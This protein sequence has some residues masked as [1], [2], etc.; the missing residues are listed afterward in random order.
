[1]TPVG[2]ALPLT[3]FAA[4]RA[5]PGLTVPVLKRVAGDAGLENPPKTEASLIRALVVHLLPGINDKTIEA[6]MKDRGRARAPRDA[7]ICSLL[8]SSMEIFELVKGCIDEADREDVKGT[9]EK[10]VMQRAGKT[11][12]DKPA[13]CPPPAPSVIPGASAS[14][15]SS[16]PSAT[17]AP[18]PPPPPPRRPVPPDVGEIDAQAS[19]RRRLGAHSRGMV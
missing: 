16:A 2:Q 17:P 8:S 15:S 1:M 9:V 4:T 19:S 6:I 10:M 5:F 13:S 12:H 14:S 11:G 3:K 18:P 7:D